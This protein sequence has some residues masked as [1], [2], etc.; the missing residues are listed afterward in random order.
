MHLSFKP[1]GELESAELVL[2]GGSKEKLEGSANSG[3]GELYMELESENYGY[4]EGVLTYES[5]TGA[6]LAVT[7]KWHMAQS[8]AIKKLVGPSIEGQKDQTD[9]PWIIT[10]P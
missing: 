10:K 6:S 1:D 2:T 8:D 7:G 3:F 9:P 5:D 4:F